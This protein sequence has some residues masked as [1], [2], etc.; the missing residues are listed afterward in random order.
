MYE[1]NYNN[2]NNNN[3]KIEK[4][5]SSSNNNDIKN[6]VNNIQ[7][8]NSFK[9]EFNITY[10]CNDNINNINNKKKNISNKDYKINTY[11][12]NSN[13]NNINLSQK[14]PIKKQSS[15]KLDNKNSFT[16]SQK[17][18]NSIIISKS[19]IGS[20][21]Q[22]Y[23]FYINNPELNKKKFK[24]ISNLISTTKYNFITFIPKSLII[25]FYR[26][27]NVYF[28]A[29]AIIQSIPIISP[30]TSLTAIFPLIFVLFVSMLRE[31]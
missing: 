14:I 17:S 27:S 20:K 29:T 13:Y 31:Y 24:H 18:D 30:L 21:I 7:S 19:S 6:L 12:N 11:K 25:Q 15:L 8:I 16:F 2:N 28:L 10:E 3:N 22:I 26:L 5:N 9:N 1:E 4:I 23:D